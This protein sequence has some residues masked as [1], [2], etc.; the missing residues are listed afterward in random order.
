MTH[1]THDPAAA[2][3]A[4]IGTGRSVRSLIDR[5]PRPMATMPDWTSSRMPNG[6]TTFRKPASLSDVA[7]DLD[8]DGV[9][10]DVDDAGLEQLDGVEHLTPRVRR[11][12]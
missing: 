12:P 3:G 10:S 6:S 11:R 5:E 8:G 2:G 7:G 1:V 4:G 9:G